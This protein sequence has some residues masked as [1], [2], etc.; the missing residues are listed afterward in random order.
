MPKS[1]KEVRESKKAMMQRLRKARKE[2][3]LTAYTFW[4]T[5]AQKKAVDKVLKK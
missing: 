3:G 4:L 5:P 2:A 1:E